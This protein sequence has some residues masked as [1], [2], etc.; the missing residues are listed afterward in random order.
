[1]IKDTEKQ[2]DK[3]MY[4]TRSERVPRTG[5]SVPVE[6]TVSP[7]WYMDVFA[8]VDPLQTPDSWDFMEFPHVGMISY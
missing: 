8:T 7:S 5:A 4:W 1:M 6:L 3:D 2:P